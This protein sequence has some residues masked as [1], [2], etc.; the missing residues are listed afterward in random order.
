MSFLG[1]KIVNGR[2]LIQVA[3]LLLLFI[4]TQSSMPLLAK[5][6][7][8]IADNGDGEGDGKA[9][10]PPPQ[11]DCT[12]VYT[13][14]THDAVGYHPCILIALESQNP[15]IDMTGT[16]INIQAQFR[17]LSTGILLRSNTI[18]SFTMPAG[19]RETIYASLYGKRPFD[20]GIDPNDWPV[21]E[22][23]V[24]AKVGDVSNDDAQD[25]GF[26]RIN[27]KTLSDEDAK[28]ELNWRLG[29]LSRKKRQAA[30][31]GQ[32]TAS[33]TY[34]AA[35]PSQPT[36]PPQPVR[37]PVDEKPLVA[38]A[39]TLGAPLSKM[40]VVRPVEKERER[41]AA[42]SS[43]Q[44]PNLSYEQFFKKADLPGLGD[45]FYDFEKVFGQPP[46]SDIDNRDNNWVWAAYRKNPHV[47]VYAG[48]KGRTGKVDVVIAAVDTDS[49]LSDPQFTAY[50]R[51]LSAKFKSEKVGT[52]DHSVL[53]GVNGRVELT[54]LSGQ[55]YRALNFT[56]SDDD[57]NR[58]SIVAVSRQPM[59]VSELLKEEGQRTNILH[60]LLHGLGAQ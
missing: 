24:L 27:N 14:W 45:G 10:K 16:P 59:A 22:C 34:S 21:I 23:K 3:G 26:Y 9:R 12:G 6:P 58:V 39:G 52:P 11:L 30:G 20:L 5:Q 55:S 44:N 7:I 53:Y 48:S 17:M 8:Y 15:A 35:P 31:S 47:I 42:S 1:A 56:T 60:F 18:T 50:A 49:P 51:A 29:N 28:G 2:R 57:H 40:P 43:L 19:S 13:Y 46:G 41:P 4:A 37:P 36:P 38:V 25:L 32:T 54:N 33:K